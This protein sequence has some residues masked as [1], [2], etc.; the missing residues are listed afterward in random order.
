MLSI[1]RCQEVN[2]LYLLSNLIDT[3]PSHARTITLFQRPTFMHHTGS[4]LRIIC[5]FGAGLEKEKWATFFTLTSILC[6]HKG[7]H[8]PVQKQLLIIEAFCLCV[9]CFDKERGSIHHY[10]WRETLYYT[11]AFSATVSAAGSLALRRWWFLVYD[12]LGWKENPSCMC[13]YLKKSWCSV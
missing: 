5:F 2:M 13:T 4:T 9:R 6:T 3:P 12:T 8:I 1:Y 10:E 7:L 11:S